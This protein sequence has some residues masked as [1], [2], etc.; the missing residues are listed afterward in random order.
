[1]HPVA[2]FRKATAACTE[3]TLGEADR[4]DDERIVLPAADRM[5]RARW[6]DV[7][8]MFV[9][10]HVNRSLDI[11]EAVFQRD[12]IF[13][14]DDLVDV[15][16][17][18]PV[19]ENVGGHAVETGVVLLRGQAL[20]GGNPRGGQ[21]DAAGQGACTHARGHATGHAAGHSTAAR[22]T[23]RVTLRRRPRAV[24][25]EP[26]VDRPLPRT[27]RRVDH[28]AA[29][30]VPFENTPVSEYDRAQG[31]GGRFVHSK[32]TRHR[33]LPADREQ[34]IGP[35]G[36]PQQGAGL[37]FTAPRYGRTVLGHDIEI[38]ITVGIDQPDIG[39]NTRHFHSL[40]RGELARAVMGGHA[41]AEAQRCQEQCECTQSPVHTVRH[42]CFLLLAFEPGAAIDAPHPATLTLVIVSP[43]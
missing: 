25:V 4:V 43:C 28:F 21:F 16:V 23:E 20:D 15:A 1:M 38:D 9:H 2:V 17:E 7:V 31:A 19:E 30:A 32:I 22:A 6:R 3:E 29:L 26:T 10:V 37:E 36:A 11:H 40:P 13:C 39:D 33:D 27:N 42:V 24:Q 18:L 34:I 41:C 35:A 5:T 14:L 12:R 8:G